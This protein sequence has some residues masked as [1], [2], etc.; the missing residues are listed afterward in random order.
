MSVP[1]FYVF[2]RISVK[3]SQGVGPF[4]GVGGSKSMPVVCN[5]S[6]VSFQGGPGASSPLNESRIHTYVAVNM[7][8]VDLPSFNRISSSSF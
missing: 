5:S 4:K 3:S 8:I 2:S 1:P 6:G 7:L